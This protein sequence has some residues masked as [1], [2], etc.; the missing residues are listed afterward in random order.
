MLIEGL[1]DQGLRRAAE[2]LSADLV[3]V[4]THGRTGLRWFFLGSVAQH[5]VRLARSESGRVA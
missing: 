2:E 1:P 5:V 3:V 4:G